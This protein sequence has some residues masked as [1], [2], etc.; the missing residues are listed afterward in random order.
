MK[1]CFII[2]DLSYYQPLDRSKEIVGGSV[3]A[4]TNTRSHTRPGHASADAGAVAFGDDTFVNTRTKTKV[5]SRGSLDYSRAEARATA[6]ARTGNH[7][8]RSR[9]S[10]DSVDL[11][12]TNS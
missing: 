1:N 11:Y 6:Y 9:S 2:S 4:D 5:G 7:T 10:H 12:I 8:A 3:Y